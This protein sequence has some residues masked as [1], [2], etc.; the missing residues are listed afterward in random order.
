MGVIAPQDM[1][2][3]KIRQYL[4]DHPKEMEE[5]F[6]FN[7]SYVFFREVEDGPM[8]ALEVPLTP[9]R[10]IATD[11][12][13]FPKGMLCFIKTKL[14]L[15]TDEEVVRE[16]KEFQ[17]FA[18]NQDTGGVIRGPGIVDLFTGHGK[19]SELVAGHLKQNGELYFLVKKPLNNDTVEQ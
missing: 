19:G 10:S 17:G 3:Q 18:V 16:W 2:M 5:I 12:T 13:L 9:Y 1:S 6:N 4:K 7:P 8:G 14:P 15:F 11:P